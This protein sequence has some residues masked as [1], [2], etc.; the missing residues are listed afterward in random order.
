ML[1]SDGPI[2]YQTPLASFETAVTRL[3]PEGGTGVSP[4]ASEAITLEE[5][6]AARTINSAYLLNAK[7]KAG[8]FQVGKF[9]DLVVPDRDLFA[10][11]IEEVSEAKVLLTVVGG[12]EVLKADAR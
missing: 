6:I 11:Q 12:K 3:P 8:S 5:A 7:D 1:A 4:S 2:F 10:I 9:A